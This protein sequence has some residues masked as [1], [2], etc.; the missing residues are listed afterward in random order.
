MATLPSSVLIWVFDLPDAV[1]ADELCH[2]ASR[3]TVLHRR[4]VAHH[5][6]GEVRLEPM[7]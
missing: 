5:L 1:F 4:S 6:D 2:V 7:L 3:R